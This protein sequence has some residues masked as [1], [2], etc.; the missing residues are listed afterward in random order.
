MR[1]YVL[2]SLFLCL[3]VFYATINTANVFAQISNITSQQTE[4]IFNQTKIELP[5]NYTQ[6]KNQTIVKISYEEFNLLLQNI[7]ESMKLIQE[8]DDDMALSKL[9]LAVIQI[10]NSTQQ[11]NEL[12]KFASSQYLENVQEKAVNTDNNDD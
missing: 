6:H 1:K 2:F 11:Y 3:I 4:P 12:V 7:K 10:L 5:P 9:G 8:N